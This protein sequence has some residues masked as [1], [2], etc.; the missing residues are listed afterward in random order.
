MK[1]L[2]FG[3]FVF[4]LLGLAAPQVSNV[5]AL[6][7]TPTKLV[8]IYYDLATSEDARVIVRI[9]TDGG[10]TFS[11][12][13]SAAALAGD[14]GPGIAAGTLK[15][16]IWDMRLDYDW[17]FNGDMRVKVIAETGAGA[18]PEPASF[19]VS[20]IAAGTL[21][22]GREQS[23]EGDGD[24]DEVPTRQVTINQFEISKFEVTNEQ[25]AEFLRAAW[26]AGEIQM[27]NASA[28]ALSGPFA[29]KLLYNGQTDPIRIT[30][31]GDTFTISENYVKHP[32]VN[33]SWYGAIAFCQYYT[34]GDTVYDLPTEAEWEMAAR[35][36]TKLAGADHEAYPMTTDGTVDDMVSKA[37]FLNSGDIFESQLYK[38]TQV[39]SYNGGQIPVGF[40]QANDNGLYDMAGNVR[41]WCRSG[42]SPYP[43]PSADSV[44]H[45]VNSLT[46]P[47]GTRTIRGGSWS[48]PV[49]E[50]RIAG[51]RGDAPGSFGPDLGFRVVRR[52]IN[53]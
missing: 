34:T 42:Y 4:S 30:K 13:P 8:D 39:G 32:V 36:P 16:V 9:S 40:D 1:Q 18:V 35:G 46:H 17:Q 7:R 48:D 14:V 22:L 49:L 53:Q 28:F 3:F 45:Q 27:I 38:T 10:T 15:H 52:S 26:T 2:C 5:T 20:T 44:D 21:T 31:I 33:V 25:Y 6:Q 11:L 24:S 37:N 23:A 51:R 29:G 47:W 43:Y 50:L 12:L 41:E 19:E